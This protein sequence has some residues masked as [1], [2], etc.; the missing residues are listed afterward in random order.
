MICEVTYERFKKCLPFSVLRKQYGRSTKSSIM[1][2]NKTMIF[3]FLLMLVF[4]IPAKLKAQGLPCG[5]PDVDCPIDTPVFFL[6]LV[7]LLLSIKKL[8]QVKRYEKSQVK[9]A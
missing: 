6:A 8:S 1:K 2:F 5:D 9:E 4:A 3:L 7:I